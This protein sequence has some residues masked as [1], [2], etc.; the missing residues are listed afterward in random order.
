VILGLVAAVSASELPNVVLITVDTLRADAVSCYGEVPGLL[1]PRGVV[2]PNLDAIAAAGV[3]FEHAFAHAPTTLN[4]H[5]TVL[6][7]LDPHGHAV[8][9][10][11]FPL[12]PSLPT[13]AVRFRDAGYDTIAVVGAKALEASMGLDRGFRVYDDRLSVQLGPM[14]QDPAPGVLARAQAALDSRDR[15]KPLFLW[16]H[17]YDP[18]GPYRPPD[19]WLDRFRDDRYT[20]TYLDPNADVEPLRRQIREGVAD[21]LDVDHVAARYLAEV[22]YADHHVGLLLDA[23]RA[24][25]LLDEALVVVTADHGEILGESQFHAY[26]HG[27]TA[28]DGVL[29]VPLVMR[30]Y[31]WPVAERAVVRSQVDLTGLAPTIEAL[32]GLEPTL[33][34]RASFARLASPGP[35]RDEDGWPERPTR[36][37]FG[38]AT[39]PYRTTGPGWNNLGLWRSVRVGDLGYGWTPAGDG[40]TAIAGRAVPDRAIAAVDLLRNLVATWD[41]GAPPFRDERMTSSTVDALRALGYIDAPAGSPGDNAV[42]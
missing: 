20:G 7:G 35:V 27:F 6:T 21:P 42:P 14:V 26:S 29:R 30:G 19:D 41:A 8:P 22:A 5:A 4:S 11:G 18:H 33:G 25:G 40:I 13:L 36:P 16:V 24:D 31:G 37:S 39:R 15:E 28:D 2:T 1:T 3:R 38:E 9:R 10:N 23:A 12:D 32:V 17:F 34:A